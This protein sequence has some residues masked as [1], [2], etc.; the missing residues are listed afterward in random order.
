MFVFVFVFV[1]TDHVSH[2]TS[3]CIHAIRNMHICWHIFSFF[4][5]MS[6]LICLSCH[7][8]LHPRL[9]TVIFSVASL[10]YMVDFLFC[11]HIL[12]A[13]LRTHVH[14]L[15]C[16][17]YSQLISFFKVA[18]VCLLDHMRSHFVTSSM[19]KTCLYCAISSYWPP[20]ILS[21]I[22]AANN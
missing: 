20:N 18:F 2:L 15:A 3:Y 16:T 22:M 21:V 9:N 4:F 6:A 19:L 14:L 5:D 8:S 17:S 12:T 10:I 7:Y 13:I 11:N 1:F